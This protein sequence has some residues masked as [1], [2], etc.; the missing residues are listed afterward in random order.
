MPRLPTPGDYQQAVQH[1]ESAFGDPE[2]RA[3]EPEAGPL[4]LPRVVTGAFAAVFALEGAGR[5]RWAVKCFLTEVRDQQARYRAIAAAL[6]EAALPWTIPFDYQPA[7]IAVDG[8]RFPLVKMAW[9]DG[10]PLNR[11][12]AENLGRPERLLEVADRW[13]ALLADLGA[14]GIAHGDLQH[15]NVL[16]GEEGGRFTLTLVDYD[17]MYVPAL[18]GRTSPEI[19]HR[20]YQ[21]PDRDASDFGPELDHFAGRVVDLALRAC[22]VRPD[23]WGRYD[24]GENLL[25]RASDFYDP[26]RSPLFAELATLPELA[27]RV[28]ALRAAC[29]LEPA[30]VPPL[31]GE[32]PARKLA[33]PWWRLRGRRRT[34]AGGGRER[35]RVERL[36][37]PAIAAALLLFLLLGAAGEAVLGAALFAGVLLLVGAA[38]A[39]RYR[40]LPDVRR[41]WR[42]EGEVAY[43]DRVIGGLEEERSA[44]LGEEAAQRGSHDARERE[45]LRE[46]RAAVLH[47][48]LKHHFV[49]EVAGVDGLTHRIVVRLK[50]AGIRT[51]YQATPDRLKEVRQLSEESIRRVT[52]WREGLVE[53]Y[54]PDLPEALS[55]VEQRRLERA[56]AHRLEGLTRE[57]ARVE[58]KIALQQAEREE[59]ARRLET[60]PAL[61]FETYLRRL[62][63]WRRRKG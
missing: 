6:R 40:S 32:A 30:D 5:S 37:A 9:V 8:R 7:G 3:A 38:A 17:T 62:L 2:L 60:M 45:R 58:E 22:A 57:R 41:R 28:E 53:R 26:G 39:A 36:A 21:H 42:L 12:V 16:V 47:D 24:T 44:L 63:T 1:P 52:G 15:G 20:N 18:R 51:A 25:F 27:P 10:V 43:V 55:P 54:R 61:T 4:G 48:R 11:W 49:G 56:A 29:L 19:G 13:G 46:L 33:A 50:A 23:L 34:D 31:G 35:G 14:A 59:L